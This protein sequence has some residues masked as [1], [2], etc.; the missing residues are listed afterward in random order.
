MK[1]AVMASALGLALSGPLWAGNESRMEAFPYKEGLIEVVADFSEN[2]IYWCGAAW[3][4]RNELSGD[5]PKRLYVWQG[6]STS[7]SKPGEKSVKFGFEPPENRES[8]PSFSNSV[9]VIGNSMSVAQASQTCNE[10][11]TSG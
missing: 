3:Y 8:A 9:D 2:A 11:S 6:P 1:L 10:R 4:V 5:R 7:A